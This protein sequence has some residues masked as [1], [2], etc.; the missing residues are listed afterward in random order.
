MDMSAHVWGE[1]RT[2][3]DSIYYDC[4]VCQAQKQVANPQGG[5]TG[6]GSGENPG[7]GTG[8]GSGENPGEGTG[9][10]TGENPGE[11]TGEGTGENPGEGEGAGSG[12]ENKDD[13]KE[14]KG[15][16]ASKWLFGAIT[17]IVVLWGGALA[18]YMVYQ[19]K[20]GNESVKESKEEV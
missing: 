14:A 11:G 7:E 12:E 19:K 1:G 4:T 3:G 6:E 13:D 5:N 8:E 16:N 10:G 18:G 15:N 2:E 17:G 9:E 20:K